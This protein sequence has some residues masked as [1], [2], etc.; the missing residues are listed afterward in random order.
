MSFWQHLLLG[1]WNG[2]MFAL[3]FSLAQRKWRNR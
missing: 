2:A 3:F 1:A